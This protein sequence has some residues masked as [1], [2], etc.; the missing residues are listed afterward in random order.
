MFILKKGLKVNPPTAAGQP[1]KVENPTNGKILRIG[2]KEVQILRLIAKCS[3]EE[4]A[5]Q[6]QME[7]NEVEGFTRRLLQEGFLEALDKNSPIPFKQTESKPSSLVKRHSTA[8]DVEIGQADISSNQP[9]E[10][11]IEARPDLSFSQE[12]DSLLIEDPVSNRFFTLGITEA[13]L[14]HLLLEKTLP[15]VAEISGRSEAELMGFINTLSAKGLLIRPS[16]GNT[17]TQPKPRNLLSLFVG[18]LSLGN[19]DDLLNRINQA[20]AW[21]WKGPAMGAHLAI[22]LFGLFLCLDQ[23]L[24]FQKYGFP[25]LIDNFWL[26][27]IIFLLVASVVLAAHEF[28][29]GLTLKSFGGRVPEMGVFLLYGFPAAY[30]NVSAAYKLR[31]KA[32]KIWVVLAGVMFQLWMGALAMIVWA[33]STPHTWLSDLAYMFVFASWVNLAINL[34]PLIKLD[35]YYLLT[36]F[37]GK[38]NLRANSWNFL[39]N[40]FRGANSFQEACLFLLYGF[41]SL[42]YTVW[43]LVLIV[44]GLLS[45][46]VENMPFLSGLAVFLFVLAWQTPLPSSQELQANAQGHSPEKRTAGGQMVS[47]T[48]SQALQK[49]GNFI[50]AT[51]VPNQAAQP[52]SRF[53]PLPI[54]LLLIGALVLFLKVP[55]SVGGEVEINP[56]ASKRALVRPSIQGVVQ[57]IYVKPGDSVKE[58]DK[59]VEIIDWGL[60]DQISQISGGNPLSQIDTPRLTALASQI[61]Q[62]KIQAEKLR[63]ELKK[64]EMTF[65]NERKKATTFATLAEQGAYPKTLAEQADLNAKV[66]EEEIKKL[67]EELRLNRELTETARAN[68]RTLQGQL[69]FYQQKAERQ[70]ITSPLS[71]YILTEDTDLEQGDLTSPDKVLFTIA[72]LKSV[73]VKIKVPQ[74]DLPNVKVGQSISLT[75]RA[76][77]GQVFKGKVSEIAI[78]SEDPRKTDPTVTK[79]VGRKRWN[80]IMEIDNP[81][82]LLKPGMTG[83]AYIDSSQKRRIYELIVRE[84]YRVLPVER[85]STMMESIKKAHL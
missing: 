71:G 3:L 31:N 38:P 27:G 73:Q 80:V 70:L 35:G 60:M 84:A 54:I 82:L 18:R 41:L 47:V 50:G 68:Y 22:I 49:Q 81:N 30:T 51:T 62:Q 65:A 57:K 58:G 52:T 59:L 16:A 85:F 39:K 28:A 13:S 32:N 15:Q 61:E 40:G 78:A 55:Y 42:I 36:L 11:A 48:G 29:H 76:F 67:K 2:P 69:S 34:N 7:I 56:S 63:I 14:F 8:E 10:S 5:N 21:L 19:P 83:Y 74:E 25:K 44:G 4:A 79:D 66:A 12:G 17:A 33:F 64:A 75:I 26:N 20:F 53:N 23:G 6:L 43:L 46:G 37:L 24:S 45:Y 72:D 77:P 9:I 1:I